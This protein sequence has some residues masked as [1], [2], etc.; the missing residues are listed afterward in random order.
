MEGWIYGDIGQP[1]VAGTVAG[2]GAFLFLA[3]LPA[4]V[5]KCPGS[6]GSCGAVMTPTC[7]L[8]A[9]AENQRLFLSC[10]RWEVGGHR[11]GRAEL[12]SGRPGPALSLFGFLSFHLHL[13]A[14]GSF[15]CLPFAPTLKELKGDL[16]AAGA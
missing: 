12:V 14:F 7:H 4:G 10:R 8:S 13:T 11:G 1:V 15:L 2:L 3:C 16:M 5:V 6:N 9:R